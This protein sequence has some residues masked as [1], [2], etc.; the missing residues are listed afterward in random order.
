[1]PA[2]S[3]D[4]IPFQ[5]IDHIYA[6]ACDPALWPHF[7][8]AVLAAFPGVMF[9]VVIQSRHP[10]F[11]EQSAVFS[12]FPE[13]FATSYAQH[14]HKINP[15]LPLFNGMP[16]GQIARLSQLMNPADVKAF[17]FYH[18]W[19]RPAGDLTYGTGAVLVR[20]EGRMLRASFD[21]P[22]R[23][24]EF[25]APLARLLGVLGP[26]LVRALEVNDRLNAAAIARHGLD[27]LIGR[28]DGAAFIVT[29]AGRL[30]QTNHAG[31]QLLH[32][33]ALV[34]QSTAGQIVFQQPRQEA[35]FRRALATACDPRGEGCDVTAR[36]ACPRTGEATLMVLPL[37]ASA[38]ATP[39]MSPSRLALV[40]VRPL[41]APP[42]CPRRLL[43]QHY[44]LTAA[45]AEVAALIATGRDVAEIAEAHGV[46]RKTVRNQLAA[47]MDKMNVRRQ[48]ELIIQIAAL[49]PGLRLDD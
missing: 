16:V 24:G 38:I 6:A 5:L 15:Y 42:R 48:A 44:G 9:S 8:D 41:D 25:E 12:S 19:L 1:M 35:E 21:I 46:A 40:I 31:E 26:H 36:I 27:G 37:A 4:R 3:G 29:P 14:Y 45:E 43:R 2:A 34:R 22:D 47:A 49:A 20:D 10:K 23:L 13:E 32:T 11:A 7:V 17:P 33:G 28:I 39:M 30:L 18:E